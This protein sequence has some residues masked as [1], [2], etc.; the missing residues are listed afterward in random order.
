MKENKD[1]ADRWKN[2]SCSWIKRINIM[3]MA[4]LAKAIYRTNSI[5][6]KLPYGIFHRTRNL[7]GNTKDPK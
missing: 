6:I 2:I 7:Y 1:D 3:K 4:I 5:S